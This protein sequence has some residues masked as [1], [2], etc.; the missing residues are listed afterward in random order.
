MLDVFKNWISS[1]LAIGILFTI[2][3]IILPNSHFKKYIYSLIGIVTI[4]VI[5]SPVISAVKSTNFD[6]IKD[7]VLNAT[8]IDS[9]DVN[10]TNLSNYEDV[11]ENNVKKNFIT[12]VENDI[13][14]KLSGNIDNNV[15][16]N[17]EITDTYNIEKINI[18]L[19]G[20]TSFDILSFISEEYDIGKDKINLQRGD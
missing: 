18:T 3:R 8:N 9:S 4:I 17:I 16:V 2:I 11:N 12:S 6:N 19:Y 20:E 15:D 10:Y 1:I 14:E 7:I 5:I 13:K